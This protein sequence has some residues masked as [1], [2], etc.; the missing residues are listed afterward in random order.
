MDLGHGLLVCSGFWPPL[1]ISSQPWRQRH[2]SIVRVFIKRLNSQR[3]LGS[4]PMSDE[5][6][7][8]QQST[9]ATAPCVPWPAP[10]M[11][12]LGRFRG[13]AG[14][15]TRSAGC[16]DREE[17]TRPGGRE[18]GGSHANHQRPRLQTPPFRFFSCRGV[19]VESRAL[20]FQTL[21]RR[22][23]L[24]RTH[25]TG[26][27][28]TPTWRWWALLGA[29]ARGLRGGHPSV[30]V[31]VVEAFRLRPRPPPPC[32]V[33]VATQLFALLCCESFWL[34]TGTC[35]YRRLMTLSAAT[36]AGAKHVLRAAAA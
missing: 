25:G 23:R 19:G 14:R 27:A 22:C 31:R 2:R 34:G 35:F 21:K 26:E 1:W 10:G 24:L 15:A 12:P 6:R 9:H 17:Q 13:V 29:G 5:L 3:S 16:Q 8:V 18:R 36:D 28:G 7:A 33:A 30:R 4:V 11:N 32:R 20:R